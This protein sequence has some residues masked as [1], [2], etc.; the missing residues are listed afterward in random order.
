MDVLVSNGGQSREDGRFPSEQGAQRERGQ[1]L[2][3]QGHEGSADPHEIILG[4]YAAS[5]RSVAELKANGELPKRVP[6]G[7]ANT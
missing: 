2:S 1:G 6:I 7:R 5:Q 3:A 4:A